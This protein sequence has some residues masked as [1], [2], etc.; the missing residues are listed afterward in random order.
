MKK[1]IFL[2]TSFRITALAFFAWSSPVSCRKNLL[3]QTPTD[4]PSPATFWKTETDATSALN[5]LYAAV[6][7][8][9]DRD[10][11]MD[12]QAEYFRCRGTSVTGGNLRLGDAYNGGNFNPTGYGASFDNMYRYLYGAI[13]RANYVITNVTTNAGSR[14][15]Q[16][17]VYCITGHYQ[18]EAKLL[19]GLC[20]FKLI[21]MWGD[22]PYYTLSPSTNS[23]VASLTRTPIGQV[24]DS[25]LADYN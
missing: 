5:G 21:S 13:D 15:H 2:S 24:K 9:F 1:I 12:G 3:D 4:A 11:Y 8:C 19:R 23:D 25:I 22:V 6:R 7:P 20:Y 18:G 16:C 17:Y 14:R 10:Y